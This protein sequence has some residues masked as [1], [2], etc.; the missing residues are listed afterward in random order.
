[1]FYKKKGLPEEGEIL[2][3]TVKKVLPNSVFCDLDEYE[4]KEGMIHISEIAPGRIR[5]IRDYV[6]E[7][8]KVICKVLEIDEQRH[9]NL[10]LRRV[11]S[12][13]KTNKNNELK[14][15]QK[16]EKLLE[17]IG[18]EL[19][20]N[21]EGIY[22]AAGYAIVDKYG[23]L[24]TG[25]Q[26]TVEDPSVIK[27]LDIEKKISDVLIKNI[28]EKIKPPLVKVSAIISLSSN[29]PDGV[30]IIKKSVL[31]ILKERK[32]V[33]ISYVGAPRYRVIVTSSNYKSADITLKEISDALIAKIKDNGGS[34]EFLKKE[35]S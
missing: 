18:K 9:V 3:C 14:Q 34:G 23:S 17:N 25:F 32:D 35:K 30:E 8:K 12:S 4:N 16:A 33:E 15:E 27:K 28:Q 2:I 13:Q 26:L 20:L 5:N 10:S 22:K 29:A 1:M 24:N 21:L 11:N 31:N 6:E 7:G 19:K